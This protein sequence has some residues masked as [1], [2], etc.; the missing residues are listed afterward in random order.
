M[1][2]KTRDSTWWATGAAVRGRRALVEDVGRRAA[3]AP[4]GC[5]GTRRAR[6]R[7]RARAPPSPPRPDAG[8][9]SPPRRR[10][11]HAARVVRA[12]SASRTSWKSSNG[13]ER[14]A[15]DGQVAGEVGAREHDVGHPR[16]A[17]VGHP[18]ADQDEGLAR[19]A[20]A[21]TSWRL[22][23]RPQ[24][25][26]RSPRSAHTSR[27]PSGRELGLVAG[28][29]EVPAGP[30]ARAPRRSPSG[31]RR[32]GRPGGGRGRAAHATNSEKPAR[33]PAS[34]STSS[35]T[36]SGVARTPANSSCIACSSVSSPA[37][38]RGSIASHSPG[39]PYR[40]TI[41]WSVS[42]W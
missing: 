11:A 6:A 16:D 39:S 24:T 13:D 15:V 7:R 21:Q 23:R 34:R 41:R 38:R 29:L 31:S 4:R 3:R 2:L 35:R 26:Q 37:R 10:R 14:H 27:A 28:D 25:A 20:R 12:S 19:V 18:V 36:C 42:R 30:S 9:T 40:A 8:G 1:S 17:A 32:T 5:A 22:Q 33:S